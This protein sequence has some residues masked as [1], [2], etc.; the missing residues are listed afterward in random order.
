M[1]TTN[2]NK[3]L[4]SFKPT[5]QAIAIAGLLLSGLNGFA[6][7]DAKANTGEGTE[8]GIGKI[9]IG[10]VYPLS[11][12]GTHAPLDTNNFSLH[13]LAGVSSVEKGF[14]FAGFSNIIRN[15][16]TGTQIGLFSNHI[17]KKAN[18]FQIA[19]FLNTYGSAE[20]ASF[21]GFANISKGNVKGAQFAGFS[22]IAKDVHGAQLAGFMNTANAVK[23]SQ[24]AGFINLARKNVSASQLAGFI[25]KAEDVK[26]SQ[27]A[28]FINIAKKVKGIQAAGFINIADNSDYPIGIINLVK[29]GEKSISLTTD[30]TQTSILS[31]RSGGKVTYGILGIGYNLKNKKEVYAMEA[32]IGAHWFQSSFFRLHTE[33]TATVLESFK[34]GEYFKSSFRVLPALRIGN[35]LELFGG[36]SINFLSTNTTEGKN[37]HKKFI[38]TWGDPA[39]SFQAL[40][41][42]YSGGIQFIF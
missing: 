36:P 15:E 29:R 8:K 26:G 7:Q 24:L 14:S 16:A 30:E 12:N 2:E 39:G 28:G 17:G 27:F 4:K 33:L 20:G 3:T 1:R 6:Q 38:R 9:H 41:L 13:L 11:S 31:F 23:G 10:L 40:Y 18:G 32:G 37:L 22:N 34:T 42:G 21:A 25:N 19:G 5:Y 35:H